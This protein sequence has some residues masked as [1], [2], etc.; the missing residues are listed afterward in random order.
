MRALTTSAVL[1]SVV[2]GGWLSAATAQSVPVDAPG[3]LDQAH[4][5]Q[6]TDTDDELV[7]E[8][9]Q[10]SINSPGMVLGINI[11]ELYTD[12]L[13]L[14]AEGSPKESSWITQVQ[15]FIKLARNSPRFSGVLNYELTGYVYAGQSSA[16]QLTQQ[17]DA[18]GTFAVI[19][20]HIFIDGAAQYGREIIN[21]ELPSG[22]GTF[23]LSNN[24]ANVTRGA[25]SPYWLQDLGKVGT[26]TLRYTVGRVIYDDNGIKEQSPGRLTGIPN[27]TSNGYQFSLVSPEYETWGWSADYSDQRL[28]PDFGRS[29][30][31][32]AAKLGTFWQINNSTKLLADYG[33]E[34]KFLPDGTWEKLGADF[35]DVGFSWSNTRNSLKML[36]GHRFYGRSYQFSWTRSAALLTTTA[37]YV[38][39]PTDLNQQLLSQNPG[40]AIQA[41][42]SIPGIPSL[43]ERRVYLMKRATASAT[44]TMPTS[45]LRLALYDEKRT[46]F[47]LDD[48]EEKVANANLAWRFNIGALT[49]LTPTLGWQRYQFQDGQTNYNRY[50]QVELAHQINPKNFASLRVRHDSR[51]VY[52]GVPGA[53]GYRV[54]VVFLQWTHLF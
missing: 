51:N 27:V 12:N 39:Q 54:N 31:Y 50:A 43:R 9:P 33:K 5:Q 34:N 35:W 10:P 53:H 17:L 29:V 7:G 47:M 49:S 37:S 22:S 30:D 52:S 38:E 23:F 8:V 42:T 13:R 25:L 40:Q 6:A 32:A 18:Y 41:P 19:P 21:N 20:R 14:A 36:A 28:R 46:Y 3:T 48:R 1:S 44:Y 45:S 4:D 11:G 26:M 16:N 24:S 2:L 15:P